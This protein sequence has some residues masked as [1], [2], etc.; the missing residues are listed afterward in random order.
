MDVDVICQ[1]FLSEE[2]QGWRETALLLGTHVISGP[3]F[4][5]VSEIFPGK[6]YKNKLDKIWPFTRINPG[7]LNLVT[8]ST[9]MVADQIPYATTKEIELLEKN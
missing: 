7:V 8:L 9:D 1:S 6:F 3:C 5:D 2:S 4:P